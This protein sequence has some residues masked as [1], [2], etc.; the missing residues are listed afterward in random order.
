MLQIL[1]DLMAKGRLKC[2]KL[3]NE[4]L[5]RDNWD[6]LFF[7][8]SGLFHCKLCAGRLSSIDVRDMRGSAAEKVTYGSANLWARVPSHCVDTLRKARYPGLVDF[9]LEPRSGA[10]VHGS[11][12]SPDDEYD[13]SLCEREEQKEEKPDPSDSGAADG[14]LWDEA[15]AS[16]GDDGTSSDID[17]G[18]FCR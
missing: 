10:V 5:S 2:L 11:A 4:N 16:I 9:G 17:G 13:K 3:L 18:A 1:Q 6:L 8:C 12:D 7:V 15:C 14:D